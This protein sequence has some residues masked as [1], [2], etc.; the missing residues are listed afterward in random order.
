MKTPTCIEIAST[1]NLWRE[2]FDPHCEMPEAEF[3][4]MTVEERVAMIHDIYP[5]GGP[6]CDC[7]AE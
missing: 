1:I 5:R 6:D 4:A 3:D 2:Y 7:D